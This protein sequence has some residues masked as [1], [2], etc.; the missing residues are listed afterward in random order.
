M[1]EHIVLVWS[2]E[3]LIWTSTEYQGRVR[4]GNLGRVST[5]CLGRLSTECLGRLSTEYLDHNGVASIYGGD[6]LAIEVMER[7]VP[8]DQGR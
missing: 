8:R 4:P 5:E 3:Y 7:I 6:D 2:T 1:S